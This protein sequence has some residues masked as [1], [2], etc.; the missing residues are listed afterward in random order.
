MNLTETINV[1]FK[2]AYLAKDMVKKNFL[3]LLKGEIQLESSKEGFNGDESVLKIVTK[4]KKSLTTTGDADSLR[5][6]TYLE[7]YLPKQIDRHN[8]VNIIDSYVKEE[9]L[10]TMRDMGIV[11][12]H[13]KSNFSGQYD[14][15]MASNIIKELLG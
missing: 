6:L 15:N 11:M 5:E 1:D 7:D 9:G 4:M 10:S 8:L 13:L 14:G 12:G 2:A 3:G